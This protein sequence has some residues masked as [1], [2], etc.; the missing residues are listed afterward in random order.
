[1][2]TAR[3]WC[4]TLGQQQQCLSCCA[5]GF[6]LYSYLGIGLKGSDPEG[7]CTPAPN[8]AQEYQ[9]QLK[10]TSCAR[11]THNNKTADARVAASIPSFVVVV[12]NKL[13]K[14][15]CNAA[16]TQRSQPNKQK[17]LRK[18]SRQPMP[19]RKAGGHIRHAL[20]ASTTATTASQQLVKQQQHVYLHMHSTLQHH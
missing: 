19:L 17:T 4:T 14:H 1:M 11:T 20:P 5:V 9:Q 6:C 3:C 12:V 2:Y 16:I 18:E 10:K 15:A 8:P 13:C 7:F